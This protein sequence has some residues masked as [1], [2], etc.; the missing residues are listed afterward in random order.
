MLRQCSKEK[1]HLSQPDHRVWHMALSSQFHYKAV[2]YNS[3]NVLWMWHYYLKNAQTGEII[4]CVEKVKIG[5]W[6]I[7]HQVHFHL[8]R[9]LIFHPLCSVHPKCCSA[10]C[11]LPLTAGASITS[12]KIPVVALCLSSS[13]CCSWEQ[14]KSRATVLCRGSS[15]W[16]GSR[17]RDWSPVVSQG[18]RMGPCLC[19]RDGARTESCSSDDF[20]GHRKNK[21]Q[22]GKLNCWFPFVLLDMLL[23]KKVAC[24]SWDF[25][26][27]LGPLK[28]LSLLQSYWHPAIAKVTLQS[29]CP[30]GVFVICQ[31]FVTKLRRLIG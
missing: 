19:T 30:G 4:C 29:L 14:W 22:L 2:V 18:S 20:A 9:N 5:K 1:I 15:M 31:S 13:P 12:P 7:A 11:H 26:S 10:D 25:A 21:K 17:H 27:F 24:S 28:S 3:K 6:G 23:V 8:S 16:S